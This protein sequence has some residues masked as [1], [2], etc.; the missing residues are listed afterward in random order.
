M[1]ERGF[2]G[3]G[4]E[5]LFLESILES[6]EEETACVCERRGCLCASLGAQEES[7]ARLFPRKSITLG[8][9]NRKRGDPW[10]INLW[11]RGRRA[12]D[13]GVS[14]CLRAQEE[15]GARLFLEA[16]PAACAYR[17]D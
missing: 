15:S 16:G 8:A 4:G 14:M 17:C 13:L 11:G 1:A 9:E 12:T 6:S 5:R 7:G 3:A 2:W 10:A